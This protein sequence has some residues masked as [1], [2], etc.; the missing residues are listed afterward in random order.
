MVAWQVVTGWYW[1]DTVIGVR[2]IDVA[3][4]HGSIVAKGDPQT[5][6]PT[7]RVNKAKVASDLNSFIAPRIASEPENELR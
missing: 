2:L 3:L 4:G 1:A 6:S 5:S 7:K